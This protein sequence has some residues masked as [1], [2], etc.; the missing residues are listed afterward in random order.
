MTIPIPSGALSRVHPLADDA[1]ATE[2]TCVRKYFRAIAV[3][4]FGEVAPY[5]ARAAPACAFE[6]IGTGR[7]SSPSSSNRSNA[8]N[9][10][11]GLIR[12]P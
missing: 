8:N 9:T 10:A 7:R 4:V 2:L 6:F 3:Q 1:L 5:G 11:S 12:L